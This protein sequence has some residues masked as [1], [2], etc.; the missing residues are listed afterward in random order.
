VPAVE[1]VCPLWS[2]YKKG[3]WNVRW[4]CQRGLDHVATKA[5]VKT[6]LWA[7]VR[8]EPSGRFWWFSEEVQMANKYMKKCS[9]SLA[10]REIQ[11]KTTLRFHLAPVRVTIIKKI[12]NNKCWRGCREKRNFHT[13]LVEM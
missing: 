11:S 2:G 3:R 1:L 6:W 10:M 7:L 9:A 5:L 13:L 8:Q 12:K 4:E